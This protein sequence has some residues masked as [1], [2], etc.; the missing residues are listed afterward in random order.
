[1][2]YRFLILLI[3]VPLLGHAAPL[4]Y[5]SN[6]R[7][8]GCSCGANLCG[9]TGRTHD[10]RFELYY[11]VKQIDGP[12]FTVFIGQRELPNWDV[13][14]MFDPFKS[15]MPKIRKVDMQGVWETPGIFRAYRFIVRST[16]HGIKR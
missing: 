7:L 1:M 5:L 9:C 13:I 12:V 16:R 4:V 6:V 11:S 3:L 15:T 14:F 2:Y 8:A 10:K